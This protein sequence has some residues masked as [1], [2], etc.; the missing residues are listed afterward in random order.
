MPFPIPL[1]LSSAPGLR[2]QESAGRLIN[3]FAEP[4]GD[5]G[6]SQ[7]AWRRCPGLTAFTADT[8]FTGFR[9]GILVGST[10]FAAFAN[11]LVTVTS[12]GVVT[13]VGTLGGTAKVTFARNNLTPTPQIACVTENG[14]F[15]VTSSTI[16]SWPDPNLPQPNSVCFQDGYFFFPIGDRRCFASGINATSVNSQAFITAEAKSQ[17]S[18]IRAIPYNGLL[19]LFATA[20]TEVWQD[21]ANPSPGFPYSRL[22]VIQRGLAQPSAIAGFEDGFGNALIWVADDNTVCR[23]DGM[24]PT[25]ISPPDL[26]RLIKTANSSGVTLEA[27]VY[28]HAGHPIWSLSAPT[29]TWEFDLNSQKWRERL[30]GTVIGAR[31]R[32]TGNSQLAFGRWLVG[33]T[34]SGKIMSIDD[35]VYTEDGA[36]QLY[37]VESGPVQGFPDRMRVARADFNFV[38]GVGVATGTDPVQTDPTAMIS[39]SDNDGVTWSNPLLRKLGR[40]Q[41]AR[42]R[43]F[44]LNTGTAGPQGRRWRVDVTDPVY[45]SLMA[46]TQGVSLRDY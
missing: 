43:V 26:D 36:T 20:S 13:T 41:N 30:S 34:A 2:P 32:A 4:L 46:A 11:K 24:Q 17:D 8:T 27:F 44:V 14:A 18:L 9:G 6:P 23:L 31:W 1:P 28:V 35:T 12:G 38:T 25:K 45:T 33:D 39:W 29:W 40:Q 19:F 3:C 37:R 7:A 21:T 22:T 16:T 5:T 42:Q 15:V 10:Y